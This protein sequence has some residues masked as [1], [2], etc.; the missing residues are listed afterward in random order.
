ME[1]GDSLEAAGR[2]S[3]RQTSTES[4]FML[5]KACNRLTAE[6]KKK[7]VGGTKPWHPAVRLS[8]ALIL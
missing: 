2:G 3:S 8:K 7:K 6:E 1:Q 4:W 5:T